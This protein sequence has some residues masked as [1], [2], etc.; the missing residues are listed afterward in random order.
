MADF[1]SPTVRFAFR[2]E[3]LG[4]LSHTVKS[5][6]CA[7]RSSFE[8]GAAGMSSVFLQLVL[9]LALGGQVCGTP[10]TRPQQQGSSGEQSQASQA[11]SSSDASRES[12]SKKTAQADKSK[13][14]HAPDFLIR[15]TVFTDKAY[16]LPGVELR[17]RRV[18]EKKFRWERY[19]NSR[20]EFGIAV[21][22]GTQYELVAH[23]KGF[24]DQSRA[25]DAANGLSS[26]DNVVFSMQP[27]KGKK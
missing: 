18:D 5:L 12:S 13:S 26:I 7:A 8:R 14:V 23:V 4:C 10:A 11:Q 16:A 24:V 17:V 6:F 15:G 22:Q 20:G 19:S 9:T 3:I 21:P 27:V 25:I 1:P 2:C